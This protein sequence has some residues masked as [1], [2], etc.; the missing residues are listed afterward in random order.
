MTYPHRL[1]RGVAVAA[2]LCLPISLVAAQGRPISETELFSSQWI[3]NPRISPDGSQIVYVHV[4]V[5]SKHDGYETALWMIP[6]A[7]GAA[8]QLTSG[9]RDS[10]PQWSPDGK[11]L[12]FVRSPEKDGK[13]QPPQIY[14]LAMEGGEARPLTETP[15]G[16]SGPVWSPDGHAIAFSSNTLPTDLDKKKDDE[17]KSDVRVITMAVYRMNGSGY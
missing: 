17:E 1:A 7:G 11:L 8:R 5:N 2:L 13:V 3:A 15:K 4:T 12:A 10:S 14:L 9:P 16:A 6:S